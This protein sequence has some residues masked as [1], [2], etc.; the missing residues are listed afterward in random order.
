[1]RRT[2]MRTG[3]VLL[4]AVI[5]G[6]CGSM[7]S[8]PPTSQAPAAK[9]DEGGA[10]ASNIRPA[11]D[12][13]AATDEAILEAADTVAASAREERA[14]WRAKGFEEFERDVYKEPGPGGK[15]IVNGD[16]PVLDRKH[17]KEFYD[18]NVS[19]EPARRAELAVGTADGLDTV[20]TS[21]QKK[22][23]TYCVS[24]RFGGRQQQVISDMAAAAGVWERCGD[25][26]FSHVPAEDTRCDASNANVVFDVRPVNVDGEYLARAFFPNEPR[27]ARNVLIDDSSF[28]MSPGGKLQLVGILRHELGHTLGFRHEHTRPQAGACFEDNDWRPLTSYDKFSV[29]H[30]PQC[31]GGGDWELSLTAR[32]QSGVA[33]VYGAAPGFQPDASICQPTTQPPT[34]PAHPVTRDFRNQSVAQGQEKAYPPF[35]VRSGTPFEVHMTGQGRA[36]GDP[37]LYVRFDAAPSI[38]SR[39]WACRPYLTGPAETCALDVPAAATQAFVMVHGYDASRYDLSVTLTPAGR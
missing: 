38:P 27:A 23:L 8:A 28:D 16:T 24:S 37:D 31:N 35:S 3:A 33:C 25:I 7:E 21:T 13:V 29:M 12:P 19:K 14:E 32:D 30:Y 6:G 18:L 15:Y 2:E 20:W 5:I 17:L 9:A 26:D 22:Q 10:K 34:P 4:A 39:K 1:M 11:E 36:P